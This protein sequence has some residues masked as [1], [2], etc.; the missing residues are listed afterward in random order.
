MSAPTRLCRTISVL[1]NATRNAPGLSLW[2]SDILRRTSRQ[3]NRTSEL[4]EEFC[5]IGVLPTGPFD[6]DTQGALGGFLGQ[7]IKGHMA[8]DGEVMWTVIA[9]ISGIVLIHNHVQD[10][11]QV[12]FDRPMGPRCV[13]ESFRRQ[14]RAQQVIGRLGGDLGCRFTGAGDLADSGEARPLMKLLQPGDV[15]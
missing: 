8:Q 12:V 14:R 15:G 13:P 5:E 4:G 7:E 1:P 2:M 11:M 10:P 3:G 9:A 6:F